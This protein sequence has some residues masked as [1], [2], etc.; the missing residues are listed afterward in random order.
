MLKMEAQNHGIMECMPRC[1]HPLHIVLETLKTA[2]S[3]FLS[4]R[5]VYNIR[6]GKC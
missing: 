1:V 2:W 6:P 5:L 4:F 3:I